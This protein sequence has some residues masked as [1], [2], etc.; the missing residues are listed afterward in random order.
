MIFNLLKTETK[1]ISRFLIE[2]IIDIAVLIC[3]KH[4]SIL[5]EIDHSLIEEEKKIIK[6]IFNIFDFYMNYKPEPMTL[7]NFNY[8]SGYKKN[9]IVRNIVIVYCFFL[10]YDR[11]YCWK[12]MKSFLQTEPV[13]IMK[14]FLELIYNESLFSNTTFC[15]LDEYF[16]YDSDDEFGLTSYF[17]KIFFFENLHKIFL[18]KLGDINGLIAKHK[19]KIIKGSIF[20][21]GMSLWGY[22][23]MDIISIPNTVVLS[24]FSKLLNI[25]HMK[26]DMEIVLCLRRLIKKFGDILCD[27]WNEIFKILSMI[28]NRNCSESL[29]KN[30]NE[31]TDTIKILL[32][33]NKFFGNISQFSNFLDSFKIMQNESLVILKTRIKLS[34]KYQFFANLESFIIEHLLK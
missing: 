29:L 3:L 10:N 26:I 28:T 7:N 4:F 8:L 25:S 15:G 31:I 19:I 22:E 14:F 9:S 11:D 13:N 32:I 6:T 21:I 27:E 1:K 2:F 17:D 23:R 34:N 12:M 16:Y 30:I 24:H 33:S 20:Y 18:T 5:R